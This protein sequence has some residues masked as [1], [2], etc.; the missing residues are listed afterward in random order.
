HVFYLAAMLAQPAL[1]LVERESGIERVRTDVAVRVHIGRRFG[2]QVDPRHLDG[3][4]EAQVHRSRQ[5]QSEAGR[6]YRRRGSRATRDTAAEHGVDD[7]SRALA[8]EPELEEL[9][10]PRHLFERA[11][12]QVTCK[13][14][15]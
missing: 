15:R 2:G 9:S 3:V 1:E 4:D 13:I 5:L 10:A 11:P 14:S 6:R 12:G 8:F 7:Q